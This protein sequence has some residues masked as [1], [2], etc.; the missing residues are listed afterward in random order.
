[1]SNLSARE[2]EIRRK[3]RDDFE[4]YASRCL[5]IR[6]KDGQITPFRINATQR[7]L[8]ARLQHQL[9]TKGRVRALVLKGRQVGIST[10]I[11]GRLF[12]RTTHRH[13][14]TTQI[15]TYVIAEAMWLIIVLKFVLNFLQ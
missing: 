3:L 2:R 5:R 9:E 13:G 1:V 14:Y 4:H 7:A 6:T 12:W 15:K 11:G 8:H 10:Y